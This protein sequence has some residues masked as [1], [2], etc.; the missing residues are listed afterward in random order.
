VEFLDHVGKVRSAGGAFVGDFSHSVAAT[1]KHNALMAGTH[2]A[3]AD[4]AAHSAQADDAEL[5][6]GNSFKEWRTSVL[7]KR[8]KKLLRIGLSL[9]RYAQP[10]LAKV[11]WFFFS[12]K[13][14]LLQSRN[15]RC[16]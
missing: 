4:V 3:D 15:D 13:N 5:H 10:R 12:K 14:R 6:G 11:F 2:Q 9:P 16:G 8:S 7:K 1:V